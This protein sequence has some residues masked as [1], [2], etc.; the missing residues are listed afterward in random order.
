MTGMTSSGIQASLPLAKWY[1]TKM[2]VFIS[3]TAKFGTATITKLLQGC[4]RAAPCTSAG[5]GSAEEAG[6]VRLEINAL[7][8]RSPE[9]LELRDVGDRVE[10]AELLSLILFGDAVLDQA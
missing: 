2:R 7:A 8:D 5:G 4:T 1:A 10:L 6:E 9:L 3:W